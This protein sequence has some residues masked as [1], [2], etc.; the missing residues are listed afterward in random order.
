MIG[1]DF[2]VVGLG[3]FGSATLYELAKRGK[4]VIGI[5]AFSP[6]HTKGN[7]HGQTRMIRL[8]YFEHPDYVPLLRSAYEGWARLERDSGQNLYTETGLLEIGPPDGVVVPGVLEAAR[9]HNLPVREFSARE[10][11]TAYDMFE[12]ADGLV[13]VFEEQAGYL[14]VEGCI[15]THLR[16]AAQHGADILT[17]TKMLDW[18]EANGTVAVETSAGTLEAE[19]LILCPGSWATP[20][21]DSEFKTT[22]VEKQLFW[23][24]PAEGY[25]NCA[26]GFLFEIEEGVFYGFPEVGG[27]GVK[28][29]EHSGGRHLAS[30]SERGLEPDPDEWKR[31]ANFAQQHLVGLDLDAPIEQ[32]VCSYAMSK[33]A[34][35]VIDTHS[36]S[37]SVIFAA[38]LSGHGFKF[39]PVLG[40]ILA[41]LAE[42]GGSKHEF[43]FLRKR[44]N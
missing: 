10:L 14:R 40:D 32:T 11:E 15:E 13:G 28:L 16:Q 29:A 22:I 37:E 21:L 26:P 3:G 30:M 17:N 4:N 20:L 1:A 8:A 25:W 7:S 6:P 24:A 9:V 2:I 44:K 12:G 33:D 39:A 36:R 18:S 19:K 5:D 42:G 41:D 31:V 38:G 27:R 35:F 34:D 23:F 43:S